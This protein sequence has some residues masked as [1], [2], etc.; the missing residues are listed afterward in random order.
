MNQLR[1][2]GM[3]SRPAAAAAST[4]FASCRYPS[5]TAQPSGPR[6]ST[7]DMSRCA[8]DSCRI[9]SASSCPHWRIV[10]PN[11]NS[12]LAP[13]CT[14]SLPQVARIT[15]RIV[16]S[17]SPPAVSTYTCNPASSSPC[18]A[19]MSRAQER[20]SGAQ[21]WCHDGKMAAFLATTPGCIVGIHAALRSIPGGSSA[22]PGRAAAEG[23]RGGGAS[24]WRRVTDPSRL[25]GL[26]LR[27]EYS[28]RTAAS[29]SVLSSA[30]ACRRPGQNCTIALVSPS[31]CRRST[32]RGGLGLLEH[33]E[34]CSR[35]DRRGGSVAPTSGLARAY[36]LTGT[37]S[38][39]VA[40]TYRGRH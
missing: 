8:C 21:H 20:H 23:D 33:C 38:Y 28:P 2:G 18:G 6:M 29:A 39:V 26:L 24:L 5:S 9:R 22:A 37:C 27:Y 19:W 4:L 16:R 32:V 1:C 12:T 15:W 14:A 34:V 3:T 31:T 25:R 17:C 7:S 10:F 30:P 35:A 11:T 36:G 40:T 13:S